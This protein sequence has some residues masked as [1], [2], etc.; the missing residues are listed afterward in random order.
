MIRVTVVLNGLPRKAARYYQ[1]FH[2][3]LSGKYET[4][5]LT[6]SSGGQAASMT[7]EALRQ[8]PD[9]LLIAGGDG[10]VHEV[11]DGALRYSSG[12]PLPVPMGILPLGNGNDFAR[13]IAAHEEMAWIQNLEKA[14][15]IT[16]D[17]GV[18][19]SPDMNK[20][21]STHYFINIADIGASPEVV[22]LVATYGWMRRSP[23][24]Y[25][26]AVITCLARFK[27]IAIVAETPEWRWEGAVR[28]FAVGNGRRHGNGLYVTPEAQLDDG[29]F[30]CFIAG[31]VG[32]TTFLLKTYDLLKG[33]KIHHPRIHYRRMQQVKL[34]SEKEC[35]L[36]AD[37]ELVGY[38]P[39]EIGVLKRV[40]TFLV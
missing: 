9:Y 24:A 6:T 25:Y 34:T 1:H 29:I 39:A 23:I 26:R 20:K 33:K 17:V 10:T 14:P 8:A 19:R 18:I 30:D 2:P 4:T 21:P 32:V 36:Q 7:V 35:L 13:T 40:L 37:G 27:P 5:V 28:S 16:V 11:V 31:D 38:L 3:V 12:N 22:R 15:T